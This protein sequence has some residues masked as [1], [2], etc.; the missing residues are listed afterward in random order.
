V[1]GL[2]SV[3]G[4]AAARH[5]GVGIHRDLVQLRALAPEPMADALRFPAFRRRWPGYQGECTAERDFDRMRRPQITRTAS[6]RRAR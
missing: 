4:F 6:D 3:G 1:I 2:R 5:R